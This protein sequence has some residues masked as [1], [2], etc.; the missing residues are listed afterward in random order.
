MEAPGDDLITLLDITHVPAWFGFTPAAASDERAE[1]V[2]P[3]R[4]SVGGV[5]HSSGADDGSCADSAR[6]GG[7]GPVLGPD[8][9]AALTG[10]GTC[11]VYG[12]NRTGEGFPVVSGADAVAGSASVAPPGDGADSRDGDAHHPLRAVAAAQWRIAATLVGAQPKHQVNEI[13]GRI[14]ESTDER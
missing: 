14:W 11:T 13:F 5:G 6:D 2:D 10:G 4:S 8:L 9:V 7:V 1:G 12:P 3:Q